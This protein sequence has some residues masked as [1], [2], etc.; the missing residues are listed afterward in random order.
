MRAFLSLLAIAVLTLAL[1]PFQWMAVSMGLAMRRRIPTLY[2]RVV[3]R[4]LGVS[5]GV[6]GRPAEAAPLLFVANH[7]SWLDI[8]VISAVTP[9]VFVAKREVAQWPVFGGLARLQRSVF[10]DRGRVHRT[11]EV[12]LEIARR[13]AGGDAVVLFAEG[14]SSDGNRVLPF[15]SALLGAAREAAARAGGPAWIQP[16]SLAYTAAGGLPI[17]RESR[18]AVAW[19]GAMSLLPH[20]WRLAAE[21]AVDVVVSFGEPVAYD[22]RA[23]RKVVAGRLEDAVRTMTIAARQGRADALLP[24]G[25]PPLPPRGRPAFENRGPLPHLWGRR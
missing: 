19:Y 4:M 13:L 11:R 7:V 23:D 3:C 5:I 12:N 10:V 1:V 18:H 15:R 8:A 6:V 2:H 24:R 9:V 20:V 16:L 17:G 22:G 14:T 25:L 21:G